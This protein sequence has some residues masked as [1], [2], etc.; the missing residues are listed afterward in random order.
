MP[1]LPLLFN[2]SPMVGL[3]LY[4]SRSLSTVIDLALPLLGAVIYLWTVAARKRLSA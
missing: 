1:D 3:G 2:G 4:S